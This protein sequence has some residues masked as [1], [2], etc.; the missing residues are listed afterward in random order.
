MMSIKPIYYV[1]FIFSLGIG[2]LSFR[3][4]FLDMNLSFPEMGAHISQRTMAFYTHITAAPIALILSLLNMH[5]RKTK[6]HPKRHRWVGRSYAVAIFFAGTSGTVLAYHALGGPIAMYGFMLLSI[7]WLITT[8]IAVRY[9][10]IKN[11]AAHR[12][13]MIRS[14]ALTLAAVTLRLYFIGFFTLANMNYIEA[15]IWLAWICWVPNVIIA[16]WWIRRGKTKATLKSIT[17]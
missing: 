10:M 16:E 17:P 6:R 5:E 8:F 1:T 13:W 4:L 15:S 14:F 11:F 3:F 7:W 9:A 2:V 12:K